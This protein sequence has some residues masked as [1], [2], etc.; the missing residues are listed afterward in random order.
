M[1]SIINEGSF[2][3]LH[4][5]RKKSGLM[6]GKK[7]WDGR[8]AEWAADLKEDKD[9]KKRSDLRVAATVDHLRGKGILNGNCDMI[10]IGCGLGQFVAEFAKCA[11]HV[12]GTDISSEMLRLADKHC[13]EQGVSNVSFDACDFKETDIDEK[14]WKGRY[15]LVFSSIT[16]AVNTPESWDKMI[17]MSRGYCFAANFADDPSMP[18]RDGRDVYILYNILWLKGYFPEITYYE[19][20]SGPWAPDGSGRAEEK[21]TYAWIL[22]D[23]N[24]KR[25]H[26]YD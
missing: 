20:M 6:H 8:A 14:G 13:R 9:F 7:D 25:P 5:G 4:E 21:I 17:K 3:K 10:D 15:D 16:P 1:M 24:K 19:E 12:T 26:D 23:V 11:R 22:W 2:L 18:H